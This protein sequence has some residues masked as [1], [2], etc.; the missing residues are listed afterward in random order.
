MIEFEDGSTYR[1]EGKDM[2]ATIA[3]GRLFEKS[4]RPGGAGGGEGV[5]GADASPPA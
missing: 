1:E 3:A 2:A 4:G 5:G